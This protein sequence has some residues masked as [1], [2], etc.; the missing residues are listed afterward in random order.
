M[1]KAGGREERKEIGR[2]AKKAGS[3]G[4]GDGG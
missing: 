1:G 2:A 4:E 3:G